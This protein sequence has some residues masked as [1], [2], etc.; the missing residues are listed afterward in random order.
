MKRKLE[1]TDIEALPEPPAKKK[2]TN[3]EGTENTEPNKKAMESKA[4]TNAQDE[5]SIPQTP[6]EAESKQIDENILKLVNNHV[7]HDDDREKL[8]IE[9]ISFLSDARLQIYESKYKNIASADCVLSVTVKDDDDELFERI[10]LVNKNDKDEYTLT[11]KLCD[12][13]IGALCEVDQFSPSGFIEYCFG[14][15]EQFYLAPVCVNCLDYYKSQKFEIW[16]KML[17]K[18]D[19]EATFR[20][21]LQIGLITKVFDFN[22]FP[23]PES[24]LADYQI[25]NEKTGKTMNIPRPCKSLRVWNVEKKEY[26]KID[27]TLK[28][29]PKDEDKEKYWQD[30]VGKLKKE[31]GPEY[32]DKM[33]SAQDTKSKTS[34]NSE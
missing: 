8:S 9:M 3:P 20:R 27:A 5:P 13:M 12:C 33:M 21:L 30:L 32:I 31:H 18:P 22:L 28:G 10:V 17:M 34:A 23:I 11:D 7:F 4:K 14:G 6:K 24:E 15:N 19:C 25:V 1:E 29:A 26:E 16:K 2:K